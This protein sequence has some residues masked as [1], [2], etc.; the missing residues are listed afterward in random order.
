MNAYIVKMSLA[1]TLILTRLEESVR[2]LQVVGNADVVRKVA[3]TEA[4]ALDR[5]LVESDRSSIKS[6]YSVMISKLTREVQLLTGLVESNNLEVQMTS[7]LAEDGSCLPKKFLRQR[8][9]R[10]G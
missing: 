4:M 2:A 1:K 8:G 5:D 6:N 3:M 7:G 10:M 9:I